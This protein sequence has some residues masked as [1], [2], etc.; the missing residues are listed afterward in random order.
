MS[1]RKHTT[2]YPSSCHATLSLEGKNMDPD[3][4]IDTLGIKPKV[5]RYKDG[6]GVCQ[7]IGGKEIYSSPKKKNTFS[8][9]AIGSHRNAK[10]ILNSLRS[11]NSKITPCHQKLKKI[12]RDGDV[13]SISLYI[14]VELSSSPFVKLTIP[15]NELKKLISL[16]S[17]TNK[18]LEV[19]LFLEV[20]GR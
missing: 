1:K 13:E 15:N 10:T 7:R 17:E 8:E 18:P 4:I 2:N 6:Y 19:D 16:A 5:L 20:P 3:L 11:I 14:N 12:L 9:W